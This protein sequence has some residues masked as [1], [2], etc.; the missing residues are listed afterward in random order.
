MKKLIPILLALVLS[1]S[2]FTGCGKGTSTST[3]STSGKKAYKI[4]LLL[5]GNLGDMSF[6]DSANAGLTQ[7]KAKYGADTKAIEMGSDST[8]YESTLADVSDSNYD[9]IICSGWQLQDALEKIA[10]KHK[11]KKYIIFDDSVSYNK[12]DYSNVYSITYKQNESSFLAGV[13]AAKVTDSN[14][15]NA[16]PDKVIGFIGGQSGGTIDDFMVGYIQGAQYVDKDI[17]VAV[18][19]VG[20]FSD[21]AKCKE[22]ALTQ[23]NQKADIVF[24]AA[25]Q[26][27]LGTLDAAKS[28][29]KYAIGVDSDQAMIFKT[30][31]TAKANL[32]LSSAMKRVDNSLVQTMALIENGS[33]KWGTA[34][35]LGLKD[36]AVSLSDNEFYEKNVPD[37]IRK[38]I[39][40]AKA[41]II[42]GDIKVESSFDMDSSKIT[43]MINS[44]KP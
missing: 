16:N 42:S 32:I 40:D 10:P 6:L 41:K 23:Y 31:D 34:T 2:V 5:T 18:S 20:G 37:D 9:I 14:M 15:P 24:S 29:N 25:G 39:D 17:K 30:S 27:G 12:G 3:A 36:N 33:I 1:L 35:T 22:L 13:L 28:L 26:A 19:Y 11:D 8:K 4:A 21:T 7:I 43:Q 38:A 44:V